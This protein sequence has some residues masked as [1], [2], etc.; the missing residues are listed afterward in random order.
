M[1]FPDL[2]PVVPEL[3]MAGLGLI[4]LLI[5][6]VI[7]R[8]EYVGSW[9]VLFCSD[10]WAIAGAGFVVGGVGCGLDFVVEAEG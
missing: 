7:K 3:I 6:L 9:G 2:N 10:D 8:N 4:L 5:D 1:Q